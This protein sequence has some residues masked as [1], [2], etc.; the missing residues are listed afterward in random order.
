VATAKGKGKKGG[1][2]D[3]HAPFDKVTLTGTDGKE[4]DVTDVFNREGGDH[5]AFDLD[6]EGETI[7]LFPESEEEQDARSAF[8][9]A[10]PSRSNEHVNARIHTISVGGSL[11]LDDKLDNLDEVSVTIAD[12]DGNVIAA[13]LGSITVGWKFH[14]KKDVTIAERTHKAKL[15]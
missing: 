11:S 1:G 2:E 4:H 14:E 7:A 6:G 5:D 15:R 8:Y 13:G 3:P 9:N 10:K 12:A